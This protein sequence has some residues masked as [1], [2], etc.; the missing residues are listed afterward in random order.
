MKSSIVFACI[1]CNE[2]IGDSVGPKVGDKLIESG[3]DTFVYG[4]TEN[5]IT[6][7]N[8]DD[9]MSAVKL[10]HPN[11]KIICV[12]ACLGKVSEFGKV[13]IVK[14]GLAPGKALNDNAKTYGDFGVLSVVGENTTDPILELLSRSEEFIDGM[15]NKTVS[16][17]TK[18]YSQ[19][20]AHSTSY[21]TSKT[22]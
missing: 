14:G 8:L 1:G 7:L 13:K 3:I 10:R 17:I 18:F 9:F 12:D 5:P 2:V 22:A 20:T 11:A 19:L 4:T 21:I 16:V 15:V 6:S